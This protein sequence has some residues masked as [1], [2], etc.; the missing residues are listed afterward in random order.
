MQRA[1]TDAGGA[2]SAESAGTHKRRGGEKLIYR[3]TIVVAIL[4]SLSLLMHALI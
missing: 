2:F 3:S 4:F 1:N